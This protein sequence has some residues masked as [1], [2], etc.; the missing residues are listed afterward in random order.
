MGWRR[1]VKGAR[2]TAAVRVPLLPFPRVTLPLLLMVLV[3][4]GALLLIQ[5]MRN[6]FV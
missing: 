4:F 1:K 5:R 6:N 2:Q 3:V